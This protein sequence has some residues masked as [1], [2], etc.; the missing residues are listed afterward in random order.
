MMTRSKVKRAASRKRL[1]ELH[2]KKKED[3]LYKKGILDIQ[4]RAIKDDHLYSLR[5]RGQHGEH[6]YAKSN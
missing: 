1:L 4:K 6:S 3:I 5:S 2:T